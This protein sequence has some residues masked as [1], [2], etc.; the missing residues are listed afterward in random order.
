MLV[1][2]ALVLILITGVPA[3]WPEP[4]RPSSTA[5]F[6][7]PNSSFCILITLLV[8]LQFFHFPKGSEYMNK[9]EHLHN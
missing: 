9:A 5:K 1:H 7:S 6:L 2:K 8:L 3:V 4:Q